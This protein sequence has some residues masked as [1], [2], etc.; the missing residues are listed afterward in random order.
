MF[1]STQSLGE[2]Y[3]ELTCKDQEGKLLTKYIEDF[4]DQS[5]K[6]I[7]GFNAVYEKICNKE[8]NGTRGGPLGYMKSVPE[9]KTCSSINEYIDKPDADKSDAAEEET[10]KSDG[11]SLTDYFSGL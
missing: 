4:E 9:G 11:M 5:S 6:M 1:V 10:S 2:L 7:G 3:L 8:F